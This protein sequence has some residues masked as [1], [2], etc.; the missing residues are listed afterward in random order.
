[1]KKK[2][3]FG[4]AVLCATQLMFTV[5]ADNPRLI[6]RADDMGSSHASNEACLKSVQEGVVTSI[7]V[8][9]VA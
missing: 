7:E 8:M 4:F 6:I 1:M 3:F 5:C 9:A 2:L